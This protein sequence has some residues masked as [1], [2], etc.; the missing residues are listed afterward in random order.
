MIVTGTVVFYTDS[1]YNGKLISD[2]TEEEKQYI[3]QHWKAKGAK[4]VVFIDK[5]TKRV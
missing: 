3:V 4:N 5:Q 2:M 1:Y